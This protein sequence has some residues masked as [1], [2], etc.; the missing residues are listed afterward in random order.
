MIKVWGHHAVLAEYPEGTR[1]ETP[2][3]G[4]LVIATTR[5][6]PGDWSAVTTG[7]WHPVCAYLVDDPDCSNCHPPAPEPEPEGGP[8]GG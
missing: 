4:G 3:D 6:G 1:W 8:D 5:Y 2:A 7:D